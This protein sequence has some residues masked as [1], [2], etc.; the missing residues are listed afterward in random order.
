M[1]TGIAPTYILGTSLTETLEVRIQEEVAQCVDRVVWHFTVLRRL[2]FCG[3]WLRVTRGTSS[4]FN[5]W[6]CGKGHR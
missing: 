4:F 6:V 1:E 5:I 2:C 3:G